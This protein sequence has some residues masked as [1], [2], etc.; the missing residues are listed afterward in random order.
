MEG[1]KQSAITDIALN[2]VATFHNVHIDPTYINFFYGKNGAGKSTIAKAIAEQDAPNVTFQNGKKTAKDYNVLLYDQDFVRKNIKDDA[3]LPGVFT[4]KES[5]IKKKEDIDKKIKE[6]ESLETTKI[7]LQ[8][9]INK[10]REQISNLTEDF[11]ENCFTV[12]KDIRDRF[13][14]TQDGRKQKQSRPAFVKDIMDAPIQQQDLDDL[15]KLY[16]TAYDKSLSPLDPLKKASLLQADQKPGYDFL[17]KSIVGT[18]STPF[19]QFLKEIEATGWVVEGHNKYSIVSKDKCPYCQQKLPHDFEEKL[20]S[21]FD[22]S[23]NKSINALKSFYAIYQQGTDAAR[24]IFRGNN[25]SQL[26]DSFDMQPYRDLMDYF[27]KVCE[28]NLYEIRSKIESPARQIQI[29]NIDDIIAKLNDAVESANKRIEEINDVINDRRGK[30]ADCVSR[31]WQHMHYILKETITQY[32]KDVKGQNDKIISLNAEIEKNNKNY[33]SISGEISVLSSSISNVTDTIDGINLLL[34][35]SGFQGFRIRE[36]KPKPAGI[37]K[38]DGTIDNRLLSPV[39]GFK[40]YEIERLDGSPAHGLSEGEKNFIAFLY[41]YHMV[42]GSESEESDLREKIVVVDDPVTSMDSSSMFIVSSLIRE[43]IDNCY[44]TCKVEGKDKLS[45]HIQQIFLMTHNAYFH[46]EITYN[47]TDAERY[48]AVTFFHV[49]KPKNDTSVYPCVKKDPKS[50]TPAYP[51]NYNPVKNS[52]AA[53]W[54]EYSEVTSAPAAI[55]VIRRILEYY[56]VQLCGYDRYEFSDKIL[57]E[58]RSDFIDDEGLPTEDDI[59]YIIASSMLQYLSSS[60][61]SPNDDMF[62]MEDSWELKQ[63]QDIFELIFEVMDQSQHFRA[64]TKS[65]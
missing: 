13:S 30:K 47:Q 45:Y 5:D 16:D 12:T 53:L 27:D 38:A 64:M 23:Y 49:K 55:N 57:K 25:L 18:E 14:S 24:S 28:S 36:T 20:A 62:Y 54:D 40:T 10:C 46:K 7:N 37:V 32:E 41:F 2:D 19:A 11:Q 63:C 17:D 22:E 44:T 8:N 4:I 51:F 29:D 21:C 56:F 39:G 34:K 15:Q 43:M 42:K 26:P 65:R 52:Y 6:L 61:F 60:S 50:E 58:H 1:K 31:V 3:E 48:E 9:D 59:R 35:E 33:E